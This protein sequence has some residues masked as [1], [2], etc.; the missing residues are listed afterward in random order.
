MKGRQLLLAGRFHRRTDVGHRGL[1]AI[2]SVLKTATLTFGAWSLPPHMHRVQSAPAGCGRV[3]NMELAPTLRDDMIMAA[4]IATRVLT[5]F[6][7]LLLVCGLS[8]IAHGAAPA[9]VIVNGIAL[10][11]EQ[12]NFL[13]QQY[14]VRVLPGRYWYDAVSGVWGVEG[15]PTRGQIYPGLELGGRLRADASQGNT[16]VF[17]NGRELHPNDVTALQRCTP[18]YRGRY[19]VNAQ[20]IGGMEGGP[21]MFNLVALCNAQR[22]TSS[23]RTW[24]NGDGSWSY[25]NDATGTSVISDGH[26]V[27]ILK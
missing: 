8:G 13:Q 9:E 7:P 3:Q 10:K 17:V 14:S 1:I 19:W 23:G 15:G 24:H 25:R 22:Q 27:N 4:D 6:T 21:P 2:S 20:G 5:T 16:G 26:D 12:V 18:V 11:S